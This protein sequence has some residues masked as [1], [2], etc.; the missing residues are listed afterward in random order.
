MTPKEKSNRWRAPV[1]WT[2]FLTLYFYDLNIP[3]LTKAITFTC[4][5]KS[6]GHSASTYLRVRRPFFDRNSSEVCLR[7]SSD[8]YTC[9]RISAGGCLPNTAA[10][11]QGWMLPWGRSSCHVSLSARGPQLQPHGIGEFSRSSYTYSPCSCTSWWGSQ[12]RVS[13]SKEDLEKW[14]SSNPGC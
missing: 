7:S 4:V 1:C 10:V 14:L 8:A 3:G 6:R 2:L 5:P 12:G 13:A 11:A 9:P